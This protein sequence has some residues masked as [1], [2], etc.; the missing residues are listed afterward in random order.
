MPA[1]D[2]HRRSRFVDC[3]M[4]GVDLPWCTMRRVS[5]YAIALR[6]PRPTRE[7]LPLVDL[8]FDSR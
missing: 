3:S 6:Q 4:V 7:R 1:I 5:L 2:W 8:E